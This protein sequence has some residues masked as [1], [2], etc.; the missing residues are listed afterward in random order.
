[1]GKIEEVFCDVGFHL[2]I[3]VV[4][5]GFDEVKIYDFVH[6]KNFFNNIFFE[7]SEIFF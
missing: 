5:F 6:K 7:K 3:D 2:E 1:L 4:F